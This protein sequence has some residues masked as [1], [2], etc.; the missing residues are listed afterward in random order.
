MKKR[1]MKNNT[2]DQVILVNENDEQIGVM[3][4]V[5]A[6]RG[7][8]KLHRASSVFLFNQKGEVLVQQRSSEKIVGALQ[9]QNTC[10]GNVRPDDNYAECAQR[11]LKEE[12]NIENVKLQEL[13]KFLYRTPCNEEFSEYEWDTVYVGEY[14]G[15]VHPNPSETVSTKWIAVDELLNE[16]KRDT[17]Q[18]SGTKFVPWLHI[19]AEKKVIQNLGV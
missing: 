13:T 6:H 8:G 7:E 12:L 1:N 2:L 19:M 15:E 5:E 16:L 17:G 18:L 10:C 9:W 14:N 3:D 4:K 11:R